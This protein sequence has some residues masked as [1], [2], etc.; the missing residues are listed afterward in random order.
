MIIWVSFAIVYRG[1]FGQVVIIDRITIFIFIL[2]VFSFLALR[3]IFNPRV[4]TFAIL[5]SIILLIGYP[6][7]TR[8]FLAIAINLEPIM[9]WFRFMILMIWL[10][11][12][13]MS[14]LLGFIVYTNPTC[15][16]TK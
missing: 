7:L 4:I 11:I 8:W 6:Y 16:A 1:L 9:I 3:A 12:G 14:L 5:M 15:A 13:R 10:T 2:I